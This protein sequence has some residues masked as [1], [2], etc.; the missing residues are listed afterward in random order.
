MPPRAPR[1]LMNLDGNGDKPGPTEP[2]P[3]ADKRHAQKS[4]NRAQDAAEAEKRD[5]ELDAWM[6]QALG[7]RKPDPEPVVRE[8]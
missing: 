4:A 8:L 3:M 6:D 1:S 5:R 2:G 7:V